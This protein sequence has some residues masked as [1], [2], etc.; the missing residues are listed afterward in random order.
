MPANRCLKSVA[1]ENAFVEEYGCPCGYFFVSK[2]GGNRRTIDMVVRLHKKRCD[3]AK[4]SKLVVSN[5]EVDSRNGTDYV[6]SNQ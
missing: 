5:H 4:G 3:V 6:P 2:G 1:S